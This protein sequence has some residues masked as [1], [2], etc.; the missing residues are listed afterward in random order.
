VAGLLWDRLGAPATFLAGALFSVLAVA[1][2]LRRGAT[3]PAEA[4]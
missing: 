4:S 1:M 3:P 2:L